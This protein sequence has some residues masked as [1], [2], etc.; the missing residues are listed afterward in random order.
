MYIGVIR[1][2]KSVSL[3]ACIVEALTCRPRIEFLLSYLGNQEEFN[4]LQVDGVSLLQ[5]SKKHISS[6]DFLYQIEYFT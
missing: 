6:L 4:K 2:Y 3:P 5:C 1:L